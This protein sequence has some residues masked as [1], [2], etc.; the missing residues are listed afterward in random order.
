MT[1]F[2]FAVAK[3]PQYVVGKLHEIGHQVFVHVSAPVNT[4]P[5]HT[6]AELEGVA[7]GAGERGLSPLPTSPTSHHHHHHPSICQLSLPWH[8][9]IYVSLDDF[10]ILC[11][12]GWSSHFRKFGKEKPKPYNSEITSKRQVSLSSQDFDTFRFF[13]FTY[14]TSFFRQFCIPPFN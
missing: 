1:L 13:L 2:I 5:T 4:P 7:E 3:N 10:L 12:I 8:M 14:R 6:H 9:G 11:F